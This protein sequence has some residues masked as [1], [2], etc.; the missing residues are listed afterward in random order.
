MGVGWE[1]LG[2][3]TNHSSATG[4]LHLQI[5]LHTV[6]YMKMP[7]WDQALQMNR[8]TFYFLNTKPRRS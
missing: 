7:E 2:D 6:K 1:A 4:K 3:A 5:I 8:N